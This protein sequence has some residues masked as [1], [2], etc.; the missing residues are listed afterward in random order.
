MAHNN[1]HSITS[2]VTGLLLVAS[3]WTST[4]ALSQFLAKA[5]PY[6]KA[7]MFGLSCILTILAIVD[8]SMKISWKL[9][10]RKR[11][12]MKC[13]SLDECCNVKALKEHWT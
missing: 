10:Q 13:G 9:Q 6:F 7:G 12:K 4:S 8:Y 3:S 5:S 2:D 1:Y 11:S